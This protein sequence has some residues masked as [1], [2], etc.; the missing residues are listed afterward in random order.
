MKIVGERR[1]TTLPASIGLLWGGVSWSGM[2]AV[3][4]GGWGGLGA[5]AGYAERAAFLLCGDEPG[6]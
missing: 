3:V 4:G 1:A 2:G 6:D 5:G